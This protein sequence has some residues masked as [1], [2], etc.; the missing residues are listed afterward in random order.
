MCGRYTLIV[1]ELGEIESRFVSGQA[2]TPWLPRFNAAPSQI[3]PVI[4][5]AG[6]DNRL[7]MM[8]WGL[9]PYWSKDTSLGNRM[10][11]ARVE[12]LIAK[13]AYRDLVSQHRC[14]IPAD[15]YY[16][17][18]KSGSAKVPVRV[19]LQS[20]GIFGIAGLW[21]SWRKPDGTLLETFTI[22][23]TSPVRAVKDIHDRMPLI[24]PP[25]Q[26][27]PWLHER[28]NSAEEV[29]EFLSEIRPYEEL[30]SYT[31]S[32]MVNSPVNDRPECVIEETGTKN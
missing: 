21:D 12:T 29:R 6:G 32:T 23:T 14:I 27:Q 15:G 28:V 18:K 10:I 24:L 4:V 5:N 31:V 26:E 25:D 3:M 1:N 30:T 20:G 16:E 2:K 7:A 9:V 17:W 11:N 13:P 22:I 19:V 8:K